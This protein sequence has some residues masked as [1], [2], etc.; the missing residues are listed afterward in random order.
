MPL[1]N[2]SLFLAYEREFFDRHAEYVTWYRGVWCS[3]APTQDA[4]GNP[5]PFPDPSQADPTCAVCG[6]LG[7]FV[8]GPPATIRGVI[9][10]VLQDKDMLPYG[11]EESGAMIFTCPPDTSPRLSDLDLIIPQWPP[12]MTY[13]GQLVTR[14]TGSSDTL[15][16]TVAEMQAVTQSNPSTG[17]VTVYREGVDYTVSGKV[18]T[19]IGS[20]PPSPGSVYSVK[21]AAAFE[22]VVFLPPQPRYERGTDLGQ[23]VI[24][25]KRHLIYQGAPN[26]LGS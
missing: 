2:S 9:S 7:W 17:Q 11:L 19:W 1:N 10:K 18:L 13:M 26:I 14:G 20:S 8:L 22:F 12:G 5:N 6:G 23:R 4:Y 21:Y 24:L 16:Y 3:C 15:F 25:Y